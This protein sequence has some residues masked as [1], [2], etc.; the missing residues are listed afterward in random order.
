MMALME[1]YLGRHHLLRMWSERPIDDRMHKPH[2]D[3]VNQREKSSELCNPIFDKL[4]RSR[5][6]ATVIED[7]VACK[8]E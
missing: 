1:G 4:L 3:D 6:H 8:R 5:Y 7:I 2:I